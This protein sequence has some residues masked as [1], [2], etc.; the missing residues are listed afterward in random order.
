MLKKLTKAFYEWLGHNA[1]RLRW[2]ID[3]NLGALES[4][5]Y[6]QVM[7]LEPKRPEWSMRDFEFVQ[8]PEPELHQD[9]HG[10]CTCNGGLPL[11]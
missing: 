3:E 8:G 2:V 4:F 1:Q 6:D 9:C 7:D 11:C 10:S 5:A